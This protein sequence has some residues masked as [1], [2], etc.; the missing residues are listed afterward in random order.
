VKE[1]NHIK[2]EGT[3]AILSVFEP[4]TSP[5]QANLGIVLLFLAIEHKDT[6]RFKKLTICIASATKHI[7]LASARA[8]Q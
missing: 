4:E 6:D 3:A 7:K 5:T 2:S 1:E 8:T